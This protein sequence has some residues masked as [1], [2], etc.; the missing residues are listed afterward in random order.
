MEEKTRGIWGYELLDGGF[1]Q[2]PVI[3][4]HNYHE[5]GL[6]DSELCLAMVVLSYKYNEQNPWPSTTTIARIMGKKP[7]AIFKAA[8][9]LKSKGLLARYESSG[10]TVWDFSGLTS[11]LIS[12]APSIKN[13]IPS[14][15]KNNI[16]GIS[17]FI[18]KEY[19][20]NN[21]NN[22]KPE[23]LESLKKKAQKIPDLLELNFTDNGDHIILADVDA[24]RWLANRFR[25]RELDLRPNNK[26]LTHQWEAMQDLWMDDLYKIVNRHQVPL[27]S[28]MGTH[29]RMMKDEGNNGFAWRDQIR[30]PG[31]YLQIRKASGQDYYEIISDIYKGVK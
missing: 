30:S 16:G 15:I 21:N 19:T 29:A 13:N 31:K 23:V 28:V 18:D 5:M 10:V 2:V 26:R 8:K 17:N 27:M 25:V 14:S 11:R 9:S 4:L 6:T 24:L 7:D 1:L 20:T 12:F 3:L 22:N